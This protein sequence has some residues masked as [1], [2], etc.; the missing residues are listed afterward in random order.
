MNVLFDYQAFEMQS[1]GGVSRIFT[2]T[3]PLLE[4]V[5]ATVGVRESS[6]LNLTEKKIVEK[7]KPLYY[8]HDKLFTQK[9]FPGQRTLFNVL[10]KLAGHNNFCRDINKDYCVKLLKKQDFDIFEPTYFDDYFLDY[11]KEKP[12]T[13]VVHDMIPELFPQFFSKDDFQI[14]KKKKLCQLASHIRV[15]SE[16]T[17]KDLINILNVAPEKITVTP[18]GVTQ[19]M[20]SNIKRFD[21]PYLLYIGARWNYKNFGAFLDQFAIISN[22][23]QDIHL[24]C[25]GSAFDDSE[26]ALIGQLKLSEKVHHF[27]PNNEEF[28]D[29]YKN[30]MAFVY[31]SEYEGFGLPI[32]EAFS[33]GC[34]VMLNNTSCFPEVA[35]DAA[36]YFEMKDGKSDFYEKFEYLYQMSQEDR[37]DLINKGYDRLKLY[38]WETTAKKMEEIYNRIG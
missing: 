11:L 29:L 21:F 12:F 16:N 10:T 36:I 26:K 24:I 8:T 23:Y 22:T 33:C 35:G 15:P 38:S 1:F 31:P 20:F 30:A 6:N 13:M 7:I 17:K 14:I 32:L 34:P 2:E 37:T 18:W 28:G 9:L 25:T 3:I 4:S 5:D 27:A 19:M